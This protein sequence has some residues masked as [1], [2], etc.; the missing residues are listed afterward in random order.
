MKIAAEGLTD[1]GRKRKTNQDKYLVANE[2]QLFGVADGMGGHRGGDV[3][4]RLAVETIQSFIKSHTK[5]DVEATLT[6]ALR[7]ASQKIYNESSTH[8]E[9]AGMGTTAT[10]AWVRG[11]RIF[12]A[13]VGDSRAYLIRDD[14]IWQLTEDHSLVHE[15]VKAGLIPEEAERNHLLKNVL[16]RSVG[17]E[18]EVK[19]DIYQKDL[20]K[21]DCYLICS[22]GLQTKV[23]DEEILRIVS[24][25]GTKEAC[26]RLIDAANSYG[27]DDNVTTVL[28]K[29]EE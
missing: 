24:K 17:F 7:E 25:N 13:H 27:G 16:T 19:V 23:K 22:D 11:N 26:K 5:E 10:F 3:A 4:S 18:P 28:L 2:Q 14:K 20:E 29:V 21:G 12:I 15:Q 8:E 1:V 9:L 6:A